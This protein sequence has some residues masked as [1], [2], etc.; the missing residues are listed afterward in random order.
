M[1]SHHTIAI[2]LHAQVRKEKFALCDIKEEGGRNEASP[3][4]YISTMSVQAVFDDLLKY[5][6]DGKA[7]ISHFY[8]TICLHYLS[9]LKPRQDPLDGCLLERVTIYKRR[10]TLI[11]HES[12]LVT[13]RSAHAIHLITITVVM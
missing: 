10:A 8:D 7:E 2:A 4:K 5:T 3:F 6:Q 1:M 13:L 9:N 11:P 12:I